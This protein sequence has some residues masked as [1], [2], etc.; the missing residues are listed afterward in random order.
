MSTRP[1]W[2]E[3][4][5]PS[6]RRPAPAADDTC[7]VVVVGGGLTGLWTAWH[8]LRLD[9]SLDVRVLEAEHVG[10]GASGRNGGWASALYPVSLDR[11][12]RE[13]GAAAA[14]DLGAALRG[15]VDDL[16][17]IAAQED[18]SC[19]YTKGGTVVVARGAAQVTR[20]RAD[21]EHDV[22]WGLPTRWL[23]AG[24]ARERLRARGVDGASYS[25]DCARV[26]PFSLVTG[27]A[28]AVER[29]GGRVH[30]ST[31]VTGLRPGS[32]TTADG[33]VLR[34][35]HVLRATEAW[36]PTL[37]GH[38]RDVAPVYSLVVATA[39][40]PADA[41]AQV[42]LAQRETFSEHRHLVVYGQRTADDRLVFG[43]RGTP[44]H[45]GSS[46]RPAFEDEPGVHAALRS[47]L[48]ELLP[49]LPRDTAFTHAW[50]GA[51]GI[52]RDWHPSVRHDP[53]TG[54]GSAGGYVGDGVALAQLAGRALAELVAGRPGRA[55]RLPFVG[56]R[57]PPWE[58][59]PLRWLGVGAGL[60]LASLAD[61]EEAR[62]GRPARL[63]ALL[64]RLT[65]H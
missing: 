29:R 63:G 13:S 31:R 28:A 9:P 20:G 50:G 47:T 35:R 16:G 38:R 4:L 44:Y 18:I 3:G 23:G 55:A 17:A 43:G 15:S 14:R 37:P 41:W 52:A 1:L 7:D 10:Y 22:R 58:P 33:V 65:G 40:L 54:L 57:P 39:P 64:G 51:L 56:H 30:E 48:L 34:A 24:E 12:A 46:V 62:N 59:E 45:W 60:R 36:T 42:G 25:P 11:V 61:A 27:L 19:D 21:V 49:G 5:A 6:P 8:L 2:W 53:T 32:V 26:Q